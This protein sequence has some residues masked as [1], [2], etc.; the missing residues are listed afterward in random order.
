MDEGIFAWCWTTWQNWSWFQTYQKSLFCPR[1]ESI[2]LHFCSLT[3]MLTCS[4]QSLYIVLFLKQTSIPYTCLYLLIWL[5][6]WLMHLQIM[7]VH[8]FWIWSEA[9]WL[10]GLLL[11]WCFVSFCC[12]IVLLLFFYRNNK[13]EKQFELH[14]VFW[15]LTVFLFL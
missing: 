13:Y 15:S 2:C 10:Y 11:N 1:Y 4:A 9:F 12:V 14:F 8:N 3:Q 7:S 6:I 5:S